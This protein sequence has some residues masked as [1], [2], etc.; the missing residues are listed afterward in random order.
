MAVFV[1]VRRRSI[2][3]TASVSML[4]WTVMGCG[5]SLNSVYEGDVR[6][7]HCMSLDA[8]PKVQASMRQSCWTE[9]VGHYTYGQTKDRVRHAQLRI[10]QLSG[11][12]ANVEPSVAYQ[13]LTAAMPGVPEAK[14]PPDRCAGECQSIREDCSHECET[15][16]CEEV[17]SAGFKSCVRKCG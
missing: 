4:G 13:P 8:Q 10:L 5:A 9:W 7:E 11:G 12:K 2:V 1:S 6:F 3:M 17:C 14:A 15:A 16:S